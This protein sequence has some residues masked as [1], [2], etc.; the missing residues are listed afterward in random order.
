MEGCHEPGPPAPVEESTLS[1]IRSESYAL[2]NGVII[3]GVLVACTRNAAQ[4]SHV[5]S[6][7]G[8]LEAGKSA[9]VL[10]VKGDPLADLNA[11]SRVRLVIHDGVNIRA[12]RP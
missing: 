9:D 6:I 11:L 12:E 4:V 3:M 10:V 1:L 2:V 5:D 8:T 7:L